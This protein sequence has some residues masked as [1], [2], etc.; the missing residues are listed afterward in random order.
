[1][2][3]NIHSEQFKKRA[4]TGMIHKVRSKLRSFAWATT[5]SGTV[6]DQKY[7]LDEL[8]SLSDT[9]WYRDICKGVCTTRN[10]AS[11]IVGS[12]S[13]EYYGTALGIVKDDHHN[14]S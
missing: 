11:I 9:D 10:L 8:Q 6:V 4:I 13:F 12:A 7:N 14:F 5:V 2:P 1:M 3:F